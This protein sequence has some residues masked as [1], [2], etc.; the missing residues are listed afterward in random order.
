MPFEA[1]REEV[2]ERLLAERR[3]QID[4]SF[5]ADLLRRALDTGRAEIFL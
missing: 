1:A 5:R 2:R 4:A 3:R